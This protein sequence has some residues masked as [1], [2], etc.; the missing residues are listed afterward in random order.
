[1]ATI[2][3]LFLYSLLSFV[4]GQIPSE[5][6]NALI[7]IYESTN[8]DYWLWDNCLRIQNQWDITTWK[9]NHY[10]D[11][12]M[13]WCFINILYP[14]VNNTTHCVIYR[15]TFNTI[16]FPLAGANLSGTIPSSIG[17]LSSLISLDLRHN[18]LLHGKIPLTIFQL[19]NMSAMY[20]ENNG[21]LVLPHVSS[22]CNYQLLQFLGLA[23]IQINGPFEDFQCIFQLPDFVYFDIDNITGLNGKLTNFICNATQHFSI[24]NIYD[25]IDESHIPECIYQTNIGLNEGK[26][27]LYGIPGLTGTIP[28]SICNLTGLTDLYLQNNAL[29]GTIPPCLFTINTLNK[30][31]LQNNSLTGNVPKLQLPNIEILYL[32]DNKLHGSVSK[33]FDSNNSFGYESLIQLR[34]SSNNFHDVDISKLLDYWINISPNMELLDIAD[35]TKI[36]GS[37]PNM[38]TANSNLWAFV[39]R[40]IDLYGSIPETFNFTQLR[41]LLL[42]GNRLSCNMPS[43]ISSSINFTSIIVMPQNLLSCK[44]NKKLPLWVKDESPFASATNLYLTNW[45]FVSKESILIVAIFLFVVL[46][47]F[48]IKYKIYQYY[49]KRQKGSDIE[50]IDLNQPITNHIILHATMLTHVE[51]L[52]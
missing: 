6:L 51:I 37:L 38:D 50:A 40:N 27:F 47:V 13:P 24:S 3:I 16:T 18:S 7:D 10:F 43:I 14:D 15:L 12:S 49:F 2:L 52:Q 31:Q 8:G 46:I 28:S 20:I 17:D 11:C 44:N 22:F 21:L 9:E 48:H 30:I 35:N 39:A 1:M 26:L 41:S 45:D 33:I 29:I 19:T 23:N 42:Y 36:S 34:I 5:Q 4:F 32:N 25:M